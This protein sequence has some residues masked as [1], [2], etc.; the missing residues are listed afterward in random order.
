MIH[1]STS[2][3]TPTAQ[4]LTISQGTPSQ[5]DPRRML[6][7]FLLLWLDDHIVISNEIFQ[8]ILQQLG[9][10]VNNINFFTDPDDCV[11]I[12]TDVRHEKI[13]MIIS[14]N[15]GIK[16]MPYIHPIETIDAILILNEGRKRQD[17]WTEEWS[18]VKG[19]YK[20]A[21]PIC[22]AL[23]LAAKRCNQNLVGVSFARLNDEGTTDTSSGRLDPT[24]MYTQLFKNTLL[25]M[26]HD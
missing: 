21:P 9:S 2:V 10:V 18:K 3:V 19:V 20:Q 6:Q 17:E 24:F 7:S 23:Q 14:G 13:F 1:N 22:M 16:L 11:D 15:W 8:N 5:P 12:L 26:Q 4:Q 25:N